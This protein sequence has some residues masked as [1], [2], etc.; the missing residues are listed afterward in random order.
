MPGNKL[1]ELYMDHLLQFHDNLLKYVSLASTV[2]QWTV[3]SSG[4]VTCCG[5]ITGSSRVGTSV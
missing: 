5:H 4:K 2:L 3:A 1:Q